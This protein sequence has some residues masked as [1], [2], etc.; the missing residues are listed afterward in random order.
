MK[1]RRERICRE[2]PGYEAAKHDGIPCTHEDLHKYA[3][4]E[5]AEHHAEASE[6]YQ[7]IKEWDDE[8]INGN[9]ELRER[10]LADQRQAKINPQMKTPEFYSVWDHPSLPSRIIDF[11]DRDQ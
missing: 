5:I 10:R 2:Y 3:Q 9:E 1:Q 6:S 7:H 4:Q 8:M 11:L